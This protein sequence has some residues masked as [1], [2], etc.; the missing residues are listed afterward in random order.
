MGKNERNGQSPN[1]VWSMRDYYTIVV[2]LSLYL[3]KK[4]Q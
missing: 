1:N 4:L 2:T 3:K